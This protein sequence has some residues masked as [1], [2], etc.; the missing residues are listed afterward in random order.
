MIPI[1]ISFLIE[2]ITQLSIF[3]RIKID[4]FV[5]SE[6]SIDFNLDFGA[7]KFG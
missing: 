3:R 2:N 4:F 6:I 5:T 7:E 1:E